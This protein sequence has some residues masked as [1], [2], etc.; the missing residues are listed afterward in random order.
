VKEIA[1][2]SLPW[3]LLS[4]LACA[5]SVKSSDSAFAAVQDRGRSVM[6]VDQY[7]SRHVFEDLP[8]GGRIVL[9]RDDATAAADIATIRAHMREIATQFATGDFTNPSLVHAQAV[10]GTATM[11]ARQDA[12]RYTAVDRPRGAEVRIASADSAAVRAI[13]EFLAFQRSD[14]R[15]GGDEA[16]HRH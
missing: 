8:D 13:H 15:A 1:E 3:L 12:I 6:G 2:R 16:G 4:A 5:P 9:D 7:T 11:R 10:P 14:H